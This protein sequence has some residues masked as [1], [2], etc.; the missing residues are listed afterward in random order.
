MPDHVLIK[1][2]INTGDA[3]SLYRFIYNLSV[4]ELS[5]LRDNLE[6][7]LEKGYIQRLTSPA[8]A[9]ILFI[10]KKNKDLRMCINYRG[11]NK[12]I[13]KNRYPLSLIGETLDRL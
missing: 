8:G 4:N 12:I 13:K 2:T 7:L 1:Y 11:L 3:E 5:I 9:S 10:F 6:E